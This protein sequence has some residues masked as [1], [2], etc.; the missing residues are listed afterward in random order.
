MILVRLF[1]FLSKALTYKKEIISA[2]ISKFKESDSQQKKG[3]K[4]KQFA[5]RDKEIMKED[6][7]I[8]SASPIPG[9][10]NAISNFIYTKI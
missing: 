7:V 1:G 8:I 4:I 10:E 3:I 9:N 2:I 5:R 6:M